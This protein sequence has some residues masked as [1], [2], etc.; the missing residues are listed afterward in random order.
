[1]SSSNAGQDSKQG[2]AGG[3][4]QEDFRRLLAT[5]RAGHGGESG[6]F[7]GGGLKALGA[8]N[9]TARAPVPQTPSRSA[10]ADGGFLKPKPKK[11]SSKPQQKDDKVE[12]TSKYRD[13]ATERR[14]GINPDYAE[15]EQILHT[16]EEAAHDVAPSVMYEQ[17][18]FLGGDREHTH[19]VKGLDFALLKKVREEEESASDPSTKASMDLDQ[20][21]EAVEEAATKGL[22]ATNRA[23]ESKDKPTFNNALASNIYSIA[24]EESTKPSR[25]KVNEMFLPGRTV[26]VFGVPSAK[27]SKKNKAEDLEDDNPFAVPTT[28]VRSR[29]EIADQASVDTRDTESELVMKKIMDVLESIRMGTRKAA[30]ER[31]AEQKAKARAA[32][33]AAAAAAKKAE[34]EE[35]NPPMVEPDD[36][37]DDIFADAGRDYV[38]DPTQHAGP[39]PSSPKMG[40]TAM[41]AAQGPSLGPMMGPMRPEDVDMSQYFSDAEEDEEDGDERAT[42]GDSTMHYDYTTE[43]GQGGDEQGP[44]MGP[45]RPDSVDL[46]MYYGAESEPENSGDEGD[47]EMIEDHASAGRQAG[48]DNDILRARQRARLEELEVDED[49]DYLPSYGGSGHHAIAYDSE[50]DDE[51]NETGATILVDQGTHKNKRAQLGRFDFDSEESFNQYKDSI[52]AVPKSAFQFG[53]KK[54]DGRRMGKWDDKSKHLSKDEKL[55]RDWQRISRLMGK[56]AGGGQKHH[57]SSQDQGGSSSGH[58]PLEGGRWGKKK[59]RI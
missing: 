58:D 10:A 47:R 21:F 45:S 31:E 59:R 34:E 9:R 42:G 30:A 37:G 48:V 57:H 50:D 16:L 53:V 15:T 28:V 25:P 32:A 1:M 29:V 2:K 35:D 17:S 4:S 20:V 23:S 52:E 46:S 33:A 55:D 13:R 51:D 38:L 41:D 54:G 19:L 43:Q 36:D 24:I 18:K 5:P 27:K 56:N 49:A 8:A 12:A 39:T 14:Q 22:K 7:T 6:G 3:L 11:H 26:F 44:L 40:S